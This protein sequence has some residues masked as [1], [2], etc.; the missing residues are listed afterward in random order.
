MKPCLCGGEGRIVE[1]HYPDWRE[2]HCDSCGH[3]EFGRTEAGVV[4]KWNAR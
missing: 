1:G 3:I 4:E 2:I